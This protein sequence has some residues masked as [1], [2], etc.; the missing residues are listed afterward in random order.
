MIY[1]VNSRTNATRIGWHLWGIDLRL[2]PWVTSRMVA[3]RLAGPSSSW[4]KVLVDV[5]LLHDYKVILANADGK[6][7][8]LFLCS[9][10]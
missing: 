9:Q 8:W 3:S 4:R 1:L 5:G 7:L 2:A 6:V 10:C